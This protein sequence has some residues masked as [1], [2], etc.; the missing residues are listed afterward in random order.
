MVDYGLRWKK[1]P[2]PVAKVLGSIGSVALL[3]SLGDQE[4][5]EPVPKVVW[6]T[7]RS[8]R[9]RELA[10]RL[11]EEG[12]DDPEAVDDLAKTAGRHGKELRRAAAT[13]RADGLVGEDL[14]AFRANRFLV[15]AASGRA[16]E[17]MP[18]EQLAWFTRV[19]VL[20]EVAPEAGPLASAFV[21][22]VA[23]EP[24]LGA[25]EQ[26]V[27]SAAGSP[28]FATM[29]DQERDREVT[30]IC[31]A[32]FEAIEA[33]TDVPLVRTHAA[34]RVVRGHLRAIAGLKVPHADQAT[35]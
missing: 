12:R 19:Q 8:M 18:A 5:D 13:I 23:L 22:L 14:A 1:A 2:G 31:D 7:D 25:L 15:A 16:V 33:I 28:G 3:R 30:A 6:H 32:G 26:E 21:D 24:G 35:G 27:R 11:V 4:L 34:R 29:D 10:F 20:A 17:P 9:L